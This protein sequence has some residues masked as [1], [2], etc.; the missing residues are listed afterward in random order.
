MSQVETVAL[1]AGLISSIAGIVLS[2]V[3]MVFAIWVNNRATDINNQMI[4]SLQKIDSSV[5]RVSS[6]TRELITAAWNKM[7]GDMGHENETDGADADEP[8][9]ISGGIASELR[10]ELTE[11]LHEGPAP[12][13]ER[14][15]QSL[16]ELQETVATQ[17]RQKPISRRLEPIDSLVRAIALLPVEA[18]ALHS[19]LIKGHHLERAQ[20]RAATQEQGSQEPAPS[21]AHRWHARTFGG[22]QR[23]GRKDSGLLPAS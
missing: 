22:F 6:D 3:A 21:S 19:I 9:Q 23:N 17:L 1:W 14:L 8:E 18:K 4:R 11:D 16:R 15:E 20:Y 5:E 10:S 13:I 7:L 12:K 2:I